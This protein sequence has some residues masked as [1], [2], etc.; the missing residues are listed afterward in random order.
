MSFGSLPTPFVAASLGPLT[1]FMG[2]KMPAG[3]NQLAECVGA[4]IADS[5]SGKMLSVTFKI[6][7]GPNAN[8]EGSW[9]FNLWYAPEVYSEDD[10][11]KAKQTRDIAEKDFAKLLHCM[12]LAT[13]PV[14]SL[15]VLGGRKVRLDVEVGGTAEAKEKGYTNVTSVYAENGTKPYLPQQQAQPAQGGFGGQ[16]QGQQAAG[17]FGGPGAPQWAGGQSGTFPGG[18]QGA[19]PGFG[20]PAFPTQPQGQPG[21]FPGGQQG[22]FPG[23][24]QPAPQGGAFPGQPAAGQGQPVSGAGFPFPG[25]QGQPGGFA[26]PGQGMPF[27]T[28]GGFPQQ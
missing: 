22:A 7:D 13:T 23:Q 5:K 4:D 19:Q 26:Q 6:L 25:Q 11:K 28:G 15:N 18:Q 14:S 1:D 12:G 8:Q 20:Q 9:N 17:G 3:K 27:P 16:P 2:S 21:G 10:K 24:G